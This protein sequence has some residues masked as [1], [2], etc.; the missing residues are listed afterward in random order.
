M[1]D[2]FSPDL[3]TRASRRHTRASPRTALLRGRGFRGSC[4]VRGGG[5][6]PPLPPP[7]RGDIHHGPL[8]GFAREVGRVHV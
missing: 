3:D 5:E 2:R 6:P 7:P 1:T 8:P 4:L